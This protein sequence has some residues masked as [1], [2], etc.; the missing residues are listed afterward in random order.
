MLNCRLFKVSVM[1]SGA[2][3]TILLFGFIYSIVQFNFSALQCMRASASVCVCVCIKFVQPVSE[4]NLNCNRKM[5][6]LLAILFNL[7]FI[8]IEIVLWWG[9]SPNIQQIDKTKH[10]KMIDLCVSFVLVVMLL[11]LLLLP[12]RTIVSGFD[13]YFNGFVMIFEMI[14]ALNITMNILFIHIVLSVTHQ[15]S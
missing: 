10:N 7:Q 8:Y 1:L 14:W 11:L 2:N 6:S 15:Q 5:D 13:I 12:I 3:H 4:T 9:I